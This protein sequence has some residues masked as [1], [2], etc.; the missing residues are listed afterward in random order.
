MLA[1]R[2]GVCFV[3]LVLAAPSSAQTIGLVPNTFA[4]TYV[5]KSGPGPSC[6][7]LLVTGQFVA[8][9]PG[10]TLSVKKVEPQATVTI[11]E[12]ELSASPPTGPV[13]QVV[14]I[15]PVQYSEPNFAACP[16]GVSVSYGNQKVIMGLI[17]VSTV[18]RK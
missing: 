4:A 5:P 15:M 11:Y 14:T 13:A 2:T 7:S 16:Y 9:T 12:L 10:Y 1:L 18:E 6:T 8:P 3:A 17:A